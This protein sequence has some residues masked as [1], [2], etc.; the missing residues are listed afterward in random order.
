MDQKEN[1]IDKDLSLVVVLPG[2]VEKMTTVHG[3]YSQ[4]AESLITCTHQMYTVEYIKYKQCFHLR[5]EQQTE[6][7]NSYS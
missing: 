2:G 3:R 7:F 6:H 1:L 5:I 4:V